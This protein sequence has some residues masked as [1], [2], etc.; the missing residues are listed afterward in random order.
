MATCYFFGWLELLDPTCPFQ[1]GSKSFQ[2]SPTGPHTTIAEP[3]FG[4][5]KPGSIAMLVQSS[6]HPNGL[7]PFQAAKAWH[8]RKVQ[9]L[10][11]KAV[12]EQVRTV[13]GGHPQR[14]AVVR[15]VRRIDDQHNSA[16]FRSTGVAM[17]AYRNCGRKQLLTPQQKSAIVAFVKQLRHK[18]WWW[19]RS[20][21]RP[22]TCTSSRVTIGWQIRAM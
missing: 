22:R 13:S 7:N 3:F 5:I 11:W 21:S 6:V 19:P 20:T 14:Y 4:V 8:L 16:A 10:P 12:R 1:F 17:T 18:L 2:P 9:R 15:A